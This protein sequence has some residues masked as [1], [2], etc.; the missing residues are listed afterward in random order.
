MYPPESF[1]D[2]TYHFIKRTLYKYSYS[3]GSESCTS[4]Q[5][6]ISDKPDDYVLQ[7]FS[8]STLLSTKVWIERKDGKCYTLLRECTNTR[9]GL[10]TGNTRCADEDWI[11]RRVESDCNTKR[12]FVI[13]TN[14]VG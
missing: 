6:R 14:I 9:G 3:E 11:W 12:E 7:S 2:K 13:C 10:V 8:D 4:R 1:G 5:W